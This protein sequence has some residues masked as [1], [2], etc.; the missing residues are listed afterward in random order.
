MP[1]PVIDP[2]KRSDAYKKVSP[3]AGI[4]EQGLVPDPDVM[5]T[6]FSKL[7]AILGPVGIL[8]VIFAVNSVSTACNFAAATMGAN[9]D[10]QP[11]AA[12]QDTVT[13]NQR[14]QIQNMYDHPDFPNTGT[15]RR[16]TAVTR[17]T[18]H[19]SSAHGAPRPLQ[20]SSTPAPAAPG[21]QPSALAAAVVSRRTV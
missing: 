13:A 12:G 7:F 17:A 3:V 2:Q 15:R 10:F 14:N 16:L 19:L 4:V 21:D 8:P 18:A 11:A 6:L 9:E 1:V 5:H 20:T